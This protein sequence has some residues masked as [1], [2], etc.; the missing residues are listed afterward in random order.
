MAV[1]EG[2]DVAAA[3]DHQAH[4]GRLPQSK[5]V[6]QHVQALV[7]FQ[8]SEEQHG[9][10]IGHSRRASQLLPQ[11]LLLS[12]A[13]KQVQ[14]RDHRDPVRVEPIRH[15]PSLVHIAVDEQPVRQMHDAAVEEAHKA[16]EGRALVRVQVV[17]R[18]DDGNA[19]TAQP[20]HQRQVPHVGR[21]NVHQVGLQRGRRAQ[22]TGKPHRI[23]AGQFH[24]GVAGLGQAMDLH[25][26]RKAVRRCAICCQQMHLV[27]DAQA[28]GQVGRD[29]VHAEG[30]R[31]HNKDQSHGLTSYLTL[32]GGTAQV[33]REL[34]IDKALT[35][36]PRIP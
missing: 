35:V 12:I 34:R 19:M 30:G 17:Q 29:L 25:G 23:Q 14:Q 33:R 11:C 2:V 16:A 24:A 10:L 1:G 4:I 3:G 13:E 28:V 20:Q 26:W 7:G 6:Q 22:N 15:Q 36:S 18:V 8:P 5:S 27:F 31:Q 21:D 32:L 9:R